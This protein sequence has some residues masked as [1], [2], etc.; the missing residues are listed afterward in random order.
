MQA[1]G[2]TVRGM[3]CE[4]AATFRVAP[5]EIGEALSAARLCSPQ[6][7]QE[8]QL[9]LTRLGQ[10]TPGAVYRTTRGLELFDSFKRVRDAREL[11]WP[12]LTLPPRMAGC[13]EAPRRA[14]QPSTTQESVLVT[15][16]G[17]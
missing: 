12:A 5:K 1:S 3:P 14:W 11:S 7:Q 17:S 8:M 6:A 4:E 13:G 2:S 15:A 10:L 16:A 9:S